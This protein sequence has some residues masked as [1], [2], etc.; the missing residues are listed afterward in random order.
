MISKKYTIEIIQ[1][2]TIEK[3]VVISGV[4]NSDIEKVYFTSE[5]LN[6]EKEL[7]FDDVS[8]KW[9]LRLESSETKDYEETTTDFDITVKFVDSDILTGIYR[10]L[11][12]VLPKTNKVGDLDE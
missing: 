4:D 12:K 10:G 7:P 5:K 11:L 3:N 9:L 2:D 6:I 8:E 1:G